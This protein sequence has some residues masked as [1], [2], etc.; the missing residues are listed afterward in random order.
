MNRNVESH[1]AELPTNKFQR[2]TF[3]RSFGVKTSFNS[4]LLIHNISL[5][6][7]IIIFRR[8]SADRKSR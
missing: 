6:K 7:S 2:S 5:P 3:D 8:Y 4:G 1:F